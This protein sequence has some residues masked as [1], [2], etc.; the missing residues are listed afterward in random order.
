M[1]LR[2]N[3]RTALGTTLLTCTLSLLSPAVQAQNVSKMLL[4]INPQEYTHPINLWRYYH[5]YW[6]YQGPLLEP[7]AVQTL[8]EKFAEA[9]VCSG[10]QT[11]NTL[12][13]INPG[14][15][16]NPKMTQYYGKLNAQIYSGSGKI[17]ATY[18]VEAEKSGFLEVFPDRQIAATYRLAMD[19]LIVKMQADVVLQQVI[20]DGIPA[21]E[22]SLP[23]SMVVTLPEG[24]AK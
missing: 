3:P 5:N 14:M 11:A 12:V 10:N 17:I 9:S 22:T 1:N 23:C 15:F 8:N 18:V 7:I 4:T 6:F 20:K 2:L 21:G 19:K 24:V 13:K 16:Y